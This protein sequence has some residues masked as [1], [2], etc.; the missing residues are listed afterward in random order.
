M[1][2]VRSLL[3]SS[4]S[5]SDPPL[6]RRQPGVVK[7]LVDHERPIPAITCWSRSSAYKRPRLVEQLDQ[8]RRVG[9]GVIAELPRACPQAPTSG[10][11]S[12]TR[13]AGYRTR[14][15]SARGRRS[16]ARADARC[17]SRREAR[18]VEQL[19]P[20]GGHQM[21]HERH[22]AVE[23]EHEQLAP[24]PDPRELLAFGAPTAED[25][26]VFSAFTPGASAD[27]TSA[28]ES[29]ASSSRAVISTSGSSGIA[30]I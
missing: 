7:D 11:P 22:P 14:V 4:C 26:K 24:S 29:A 2:A 20:A 16:A 3:A 25:S 27:S 5:R 18:S 30:L 9:P 23:L 21:D 12:P 13:A 28:P 1:I 19:Q 6:E 8:L 17:D 10:S 15:A